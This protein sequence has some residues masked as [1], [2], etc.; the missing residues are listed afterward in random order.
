MPYTEIFNLADKLHDSRDG[1]RWKLLKFG[2]GFHYNQMNKYVAWLQK[3]GATFEVRQ[4]GLT[5]LVK[6]NIGSLL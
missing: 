3:H 6:S 4:R 5:L 2:E 1:K